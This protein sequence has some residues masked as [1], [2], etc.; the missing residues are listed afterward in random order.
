MLAFKEVSEL[1]G[2]TARVHEMISVFKDV[3]GGKYF[4]RG[5]ATEEG[6]DIRKQRGLVEE[7][8]FVK[9]EDVPIVSPN[10]DVLVEV[11]N[12]LEVKFRFPYLEKKSGSNYCTFLLLVT[13]GT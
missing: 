4:K 13:Q 11:S 2:Y 7:G 6:V 12:R 5:V 10:G 8:D 9:F 1:A 3:S